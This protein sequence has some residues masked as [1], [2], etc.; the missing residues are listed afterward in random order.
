MATGRD[1]EDKKL[2][3]V[4]SPTLILWGREDMLIPLAMGERFHQEIADSEMVV[5]ENTGHIPMVGKPAE[6]NAA[7][8]KFLQD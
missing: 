3:K 7:V 5:I 8:S 6:F 4:Q 1:F 2:G